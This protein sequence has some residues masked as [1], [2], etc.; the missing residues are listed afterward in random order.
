[1]SRGSRFLSFVLRHKPEEI[2]LELG[3]GGWVNLD[4]LVRALR[5]AGRPMSR[6]EIMQTVAT[7]QKGRFTISADGTEIRAAQG[8]SV[9]IALGLAVSAPPAVLYHGTARHKLDEIFSSGL[10]P[11]KRHHV[12]LSSS[13]HAAA[14]VGARHGKPVILKIDALAMHQEGHEFYVSDNGIWLTAVV[15]T[16]FLGFAENFT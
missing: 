5:Q 7:D 8:H 16:N 4:I 9:P 1:M 13:R 10:L 11:M 6:T 3:S 12:H 14:S 2:G 15:P